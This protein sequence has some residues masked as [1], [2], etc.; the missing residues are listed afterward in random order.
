M[1]LALQHDGGAGELLDGVEDRV[2][3]GLGYAELG[4]GVVHALCLTELDELL[5]DQP[6]PDGLGDRGEADLASQCDEREAAGVAGGHERFR[7]DAPPSAELDEQS[8]G[9]GL[10]QALRERRQRLGALGHRYARGQDQVPATQ[11]RTDVGQLGGVD[12][13]DPAVQVVGAGQHD[14]VGAAHRRHRQHV[15]DRQHVLIVTE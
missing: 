10:G 6:F 5:V 11:Q 12:P 13:A 15:G 2:G 14:R 1:L 7:Q 8:G 4:E 3:S 9:L